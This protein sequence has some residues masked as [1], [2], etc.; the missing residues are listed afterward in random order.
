[1]IRQLIIA[2]AA[3]T[4]VGCT[5]SGALD[6]GSKEDTAKYVNFAASAKMPTTAPASDANVAALMSGGTLKIY[7]FTRMN[8]DDAAVWINGMYVTK[9]DSIPAM[10]ETSVDFS[11]FYSSAGIELNTD[12]TPVKTV[13]IESGNGVHSLLG[14]LSE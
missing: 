7:N 9:V 1:M 14:P 12:K 10:S 2:A 6:I 3:A 4:L 11:H 8:M 5:S 13:S